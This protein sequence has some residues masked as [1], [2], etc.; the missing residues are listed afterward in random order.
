MS[1]KFSTYFVEKWQFLY[2]SIFFYFKIA[3]LW[4][5]TTHTL[6]H[7]KISKFIILSFIMQ[8][9]TVMISL[10]GGNIPC[11]ILQLMDFFQFILLG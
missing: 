2:F 1:L 8:I 4:P 7:L 6:G 3:A 10:I 11:H 5:H 9:S